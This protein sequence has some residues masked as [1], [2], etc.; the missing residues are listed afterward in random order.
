[1]DVEKSLNISVFC[2]NYFIPANR[3]ISKNNIVFPFPL[4]NFFH[5]TRPGSW[6]LTGGAKIQRL[7][8]MTFWGTGLSERQ[9][10]GTGQF[11]STMP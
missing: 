9:T 2:D 1:M 11:T 5:M 10:A 7:T 8:A 3:I 6:Y 4:G